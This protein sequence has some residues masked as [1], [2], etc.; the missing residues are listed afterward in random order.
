MLVGCKSE[1]QPPSVWEQYDVRQPLPYDSQ[2][3]DSSVNQ[4]NRYDPYRYP[5]IDNDA[6]YQPPNSPAGYVYNPDALD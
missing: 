3:P 2:V 6:Y 4:I 5:P 1:P